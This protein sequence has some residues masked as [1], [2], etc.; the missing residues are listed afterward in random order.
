M[1][2]RELSENCL[3]PFFLFLIR[4]KSGTLV[5]IT[6]K[7]NRKEY[8]KLTNDQFWEIIEKSRLDRPREQHDILYD[9]LIQLPAD[10][11]QSFANHFWVRAAEADRY[12][13]AALANL[14]E[15]GI[16]DDAFQEFQ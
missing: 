9:L 13:L 6:T 4:K 14:I 3:S 16:S 11:A 12:D 7:E 8:D 1:A 2:S 5:C 10:E 15:G